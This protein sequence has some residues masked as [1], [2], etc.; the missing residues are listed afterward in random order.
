MAR[1]RMIEVTIAHDKAF[2]SLSEFAQLLYL[3][4][5]PH[6]DDYGRFEADVDVFKVRVDPFNKRPIED[7]EKAMKEI[8]EVHL[9]SIY[10]TDGEKRVLQF[11]QQSFERI[12]AFLIK[13]RG[14]CEYPAYMEAYQLICGDM[15]AYHIIS[16]KNKVKSKEKKETVVDKNLNGESAH[17]ESVS[18]VIRLF[19]ERNYLDANTEGEKFWNYY[20]SNGWRVGRNPMKNWKAAA[21]NWNKNAKQYHKGGVILPSGPRSPQFKKCHIHR[22]EY[23]E[24]LCPKCTLPMPESL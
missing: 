18:I 14:N 10:S 5:L 3:R 6:T 8:A 19:Q 22:I 12:N 4:T 1:R 2:N 21:A 16:I 7:Y 15:P 9:W 13:N 17:P 20:E 23:T 24:P 11:D